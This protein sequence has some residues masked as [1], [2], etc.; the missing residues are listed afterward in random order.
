MEAALMKWIAARILFEASDTT[1]AVELI[2]DLF[3]RVGIEGLVIEDP[4]L[5]PDETTDGWEDNPRFRPE[6]HAV[7]GYL[8]NNDQGRRRLEML[9]QGL[10]GLA[11]RGKVRC[12]LESGIIDEE[13]WAEAWKSF[14]WPEKV[15]R[16]IVIKPTWRDYGAGPDDLV[17]EIDPGMAFGTGTHATTAMCIRML[18]RYLL[19]EHRLLDV[20]CG[21]GIL[22]AVAA[23]LGC[24]AMAGVDHDQVAVDVTRRNLTQN[25]IPP[26]HYT[27]TTGNL[28]QGIDRTFDLVTANILSDVILQLLDSVQRT[29]KPG[30]VLICSGI[31]TTR[32]AAVGRKI[33]K[34]GMTVEATER[35]DG[36]VALAARRP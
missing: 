36:W 35:Q 5:A 2:T 13:D 27:L 18:E 24:S 25:R 15:G 26:G 6:N 16:R 31:I 22:L 1:G 9:S 17:V 14:F 3:A 32:E 12:R 11:E 34:V 4:R 28:V 19:P 30:G 21:S 23:K 29:M 20:G 8:A 7:T 33:A 10:P